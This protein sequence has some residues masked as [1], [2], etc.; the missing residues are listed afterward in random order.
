MADLKRLKVADKGNP[1]AAAQVTG[2]LKSAP[3][4]TPEAKARLEFS[5]P[6]SVFQEFSEEAARRFGAKKGSKV[7]LFLELWENSQ[8][9]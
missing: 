7:K 2:N 6:E 3:R 5:V 1:P 8:T 4:E 9:P